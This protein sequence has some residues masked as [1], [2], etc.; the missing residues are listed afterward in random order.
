METAWSVFY[1]AV[2]TLGMLHGIADA[3]QIPYDQK[4]IFIWIV[5]SSVIWGIAFGWKRH[6]KYLFPAAVGLFVWI[7]LWRWKEICEG[8][9][10]S[11][12]RMTEAINAYYQFSWDTVQYVKTG[13]ISTE[14][15]AILVAGVFVSGLLVGGFLQKKG[16]ILLAVLFAFGFLAPFLVGKVPENRTVWELLIGIMGLLAMQTALPG[17]QRKIKF[18]GT[19]N[20]MLIGIAAIAFVGSAFVL[21]PLLQ[22]IFPPD[23]PKQKLV[24]EELWQD[25][26]RST[27]ENVRTDI[28]AGG[29]GNGD[30]SVADRLEPGKEPQLKVTVGEKPQTDLYLYGYI[31]ADYNR[32]QWER[33]E[34]S[35]R[36]Q[37]GRREALEERKGDVYRWL[38]KKKDEK[39][40]SVEYEDT[41]KAYEYLPYGSKIRNEQEVWGDTYVKGT[42][43]TTY[44][45][46][47]CEL[48]EADWQERTGKK[49]EEILRK[50]SEYD[51]FVSKQ[52]LKIDAEQK[53]KLQQIPLEGETL[54]EISAAMEQWLGAHTS[55][56]LSPGKVPWGKEYV[57]YFLFENKKGYCVHYA[58]AATLL[59]RSHDIPARFV[60]GYLIGKEQWK[61]SDDGTYQV[62]VTGAD[63]HAWTEI[64]TGD[65][66]WIPVELTPTYGRDDT[67]KAH[68]TDLANVSPEVSGEDS[69]R[70]S[71]DSQMAE[72]NIPKEHETGT[73]EAND[74]NVENQQQGT[75]K[76][77]A[78]NV[79]V[80]KE[81]NGTKSN[82]LIKRI[83]QLLLFILMS[84][85]SFGAW[86]FYKVQ[87]RQ[88]IFAKNRNE[89]AQKIFFSLYEVLRFAGMAEND[90]LGDEFG[91]EA[92]KVCDKMEVQIKVAQQ[93]AL[94]AWYSGGTISDKEERELCRTYRNVCRLI[95]EKLT[96]REKILFYFTKCFL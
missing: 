62:T 69:Q 78:T 8:I 90:C 44:T 7:G 41:E 33:M 50:T 53:K 87:Q 82:L 76:N 43:K 25:I 19:A 9:C 21:E 39:K 6:R 5:L 94:K 30:L 49:C 37:L 14:Q 79:D 95:S 38:K 70:V 66:I 10:R 47:F 28:A 75:E 63:A 15:T 84:I 36:D 60:S 83:K 3:F 56:S 65:G 89:K 12:E 74:K 48:S 34:S 58:T 29:I 85:I 73:K 1:G 81:D 24:L 61:T 93:T 2:G 11:M 31:G 57:E 23:S 45:T 92:K 52:Y 51:L 32:K 18:F 16:R 22:T 68:G 71:S 80:E 40:L 13:G 64:Y 96:F 27:R 42:G 86:R 46:S 55:Y 35:A 72:S 67:S 77:A 26:R 91:Q 88:G 17:K 59:F 4:M 20:G 54:F